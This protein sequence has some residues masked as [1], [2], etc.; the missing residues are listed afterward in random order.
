MK[1]IL[2]TL[3]TAIISM[4]VNAQQWEIDYGDSFSYT[5]LYQGI[6]NA[7][8]DAIV[9]GVWGEDKYHYRPMTMQV[10][11]EGNYDIHTFEDE[12]FNMF[13][14]SDFLQMENGNYF[15][16]G[17]KESALVAVVFDS[18]FNVINVKAYEKPEIAISLGRGSLLLDDDGTMVFSGGYN[19]Q[20]VYG[21]R[22]KPYFY[23]FDEN[24]DT[25]S[26]RFVTAE[27]PHP[28]ATIYEYDCFQLLKNPKSDGFVVLCNGLGNVCSLLKYDNNFSYEDGFKLIPAHPQHFEN[29]YSGHW[30]SDDK[31]FVMGYMWPYQEL[32][33]W[34][35]G[36]AE[37]G[38]DGTFDRFERVYYKQDTAVKAPPKCMAYVNDTTMYGITHI[39]QNVLSGPYYTGVFLFDKDME[40]LGKRE[41]YEPEYENHVTLPGFIIPLPDGGCLFNAEVSTLFLGDYTYGKLIKMRREDFNPIPC[42]VKEVPQEAIKALAYPNPAK[43]ELNIDI[44]GLPE[45]HEHRIQI[46][47]ALGHICM[48]RIIRG[49]GNVLTLGVSGLKAGIYV[50]SIYNAKKEIARNKFIKE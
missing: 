47:D 18:N 24:A 13:Y 4:A 22:T 12:Q 2:F 11:M 8:G 50:Y 44:S 28:E 42:S 3:L 5:S 34:N 37:I 17:I 14:P 29:A 33:E 48:D 25:L 7:D 38:L 36:L 39:F 31:L 27:L 6:I 19:Y 43:D 1:R 32:T 45:H 9:M 40:V 35:I 16:V 26:S 30:L 23:R 10:D 46:T 15:V 49:E 41:F 21:Q 20:D